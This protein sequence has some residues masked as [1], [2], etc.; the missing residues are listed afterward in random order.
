MNSLQPVAAVATVGHVGVGPA[1]ELVFLVAVFALNRD[2][3]K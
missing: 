3:K 2:G 1:D